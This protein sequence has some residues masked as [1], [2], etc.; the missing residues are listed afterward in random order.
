MGK[1]IT[2]AGGRFVE[3]IEGKKLKRAPRAINFRVSFDYTGS[4][5]TTVARQVAKEMNLDVETITVKRP[6]R[7]RSRADRLAEA[8]SMI[9]DAKQMVEEL[10]QEMEDWYEQIPDNLKDADKGSQVQECSEALR[11]LVDGIEQLSFDSISFP[12]MY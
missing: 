4:A 9:E 2:I 12:G 10:Q 1:R 5:E 8:N 3:V 6:R 11:E 7:I